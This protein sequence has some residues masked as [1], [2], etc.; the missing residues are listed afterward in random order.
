MSQ[1]Q[2][3]LMAQQFHTPQTLSQYALPPGKTFCIIL[4]SVQC[5][6]NAITLFLSSFFDFSIVVY[7][8]GIFFNSDTVFIGSFLSFQFSNLSHQS[9]IFPYN[10]L[11]PNIAIFIL[12]TISHPNLIQAHNIIL[13]LLSTS[14]SISILTLNLLASLK[15][16]V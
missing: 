3:F 9:H 8:S 14:S 15:K 10:Q 1:F 12:A 2:K 6:N 11:A 13:N 16:S 4:L 7:I 5:S